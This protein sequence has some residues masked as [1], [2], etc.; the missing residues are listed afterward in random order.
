M[1]SSYFRERQ[2]EES[3]NFFCQFTFGQFFALLVIEVFTLFFVF[4]LGAR[5]GREFLG[6]KNDNI[7]IAT[8]KNPSESVGD[9]PKVVTTADPE[10]TK[11]AN[12]LMAEAKTPELK[13]RINKMF[14]NAKQEEKI[15]EAPS[16]DVLTETEP[17]QE[18]SAVPDEENKSEADKG[19]SVVRVK[20]VANAR[21][22]VQVGSYPKMDEATTSVEK[23]KTKGY[24]AYM[25]IADI[26]ERGRW[27]RVRIGGF[28]THE[29]AASYLKDFKSKENVEALVVMNEQ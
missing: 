12:E 8:E 13:D 2:G 14:D 1:N 6:F 5:Y 22:S 10:A 21:Y 17:T 18:K 9:S 3:D 23:W 19:T 26:P 27:Y 24:A 29:D 15:A 7:V 20:S 16:E 25:M 11:I 4:Y 28:G